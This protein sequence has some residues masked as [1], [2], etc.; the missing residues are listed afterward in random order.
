MVQSRA[1][2]AL[3]SSSKGA[4]ASTGPLKGP[5]L[6]ARA[7]STRRTNLVIHLGQFGL[8]L[9]L[10]FGQSI[11]SQCILPGRVVLMIRQPLCFSAAID[12]P[13]E[14]NL[15]WELASEHELRLVC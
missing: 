12:K 14:S 15:L 1:D 8:P 5:I 7:L 13:P 3:V 10:V 4:P 6:N 9:F 2:E 11:I